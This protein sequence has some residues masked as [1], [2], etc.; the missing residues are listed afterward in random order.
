MSTVRFYNNS[1][2]VILAGNLAGS[3]VCLVTS[4]YV[5]DPAHSGYSDISADELPTGNGYTAGGAALENLAI[6]GTAGTLTITTSGCSWSTLTATFRYAILMDSNS[7]LIACHTLS[8]ADITISASNYML[9]LPETKLF[10]GTIAQS[11]T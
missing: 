9:E 11:T 10:T 3:R 1:M 8:D 6:S 2:P 4:A 7:N 5:Y